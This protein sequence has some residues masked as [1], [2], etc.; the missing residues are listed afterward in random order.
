MLEREGPGSE[1]QLHGAR[2]MG[3]C[4]LLTSPPSIFNMLLVMGICLLEPGG[5]F[6]D[7]VRV[8]SL[9]RANDTQE[10]LDK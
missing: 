9:S 8:I 10:A 3:V 5:R 6:S 2:P 1:L 4:E 7:M